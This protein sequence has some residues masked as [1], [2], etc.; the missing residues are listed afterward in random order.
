[1]LSPT[2]QS[3]PPGIS[4]FNKEKTS[5]ETATKLDLISSIWDDDHIRRLDEKNWQCLWC[6]QTFQVINATKALAHLLG[7]EGMHIKSCYVAKD[8]YHTTRYQEL[9]NYKQACKGILHEYPENIRTSITSLQNKSSS[10]IE[11]T[12][13]RSSKKYHFIK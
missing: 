4:F 1:M 11:S 6:N 12:I 2:S 8:K 7:K 9:Q 3:F 13:H 5:A 10:A